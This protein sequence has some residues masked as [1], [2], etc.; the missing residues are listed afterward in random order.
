MLLGRGGA[1]PLHVVDFY[2]VLKHLAPFV[3][4]IAPMLLTFVL[5]FALRSFGH[6]HRIASR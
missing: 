5:A 6:P 3:F 2:R 1:A 4:V